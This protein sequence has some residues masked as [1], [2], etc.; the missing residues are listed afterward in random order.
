MEGLAH[1]SSLSSIKYGRPSGPRQR[2]W[3]H[4]WIPCSHSGA[5]FRRRN[6]AKVKGC[7]SNGHPSSSRWI[8]IF[9]EMEVDIWLPDQISG[10]PTGWRSAVS[11]VAMLRATIEKHMGVRPR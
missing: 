5:S 1:C 3:D 8:R 2:I 11:R 4:L 10:P 7:T 9:D 6:V